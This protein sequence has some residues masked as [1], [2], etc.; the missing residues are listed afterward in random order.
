MK[1]WQ[2]AWASSGL[3]FQGAKIGLKIHI[4]KT[5]SPRLEIS[6]GKKVMMGNGESDQVDSFIYL[7]SIISTGGGCIEDV[8]CRI[9][10]ARGVFN[11]WERFG[12]I[13]D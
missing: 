13:E 8:K 4:K 5:K 9:A 1:C 11:G 3:R 7:G 10:K 6:E 12:R 2:N